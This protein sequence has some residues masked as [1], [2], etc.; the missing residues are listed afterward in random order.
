MGRVKPSYH[1]KVVEEAVS[2]PHYG[3]HENIM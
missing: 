3:I 2:N 1:T